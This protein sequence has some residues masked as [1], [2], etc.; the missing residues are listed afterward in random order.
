MCGHNGGY[1]EKYKTE[2]TNT[3]QLYYNLHHKCDYFVFLLI[4]YDI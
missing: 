4:C 3:L 2:H 1:R